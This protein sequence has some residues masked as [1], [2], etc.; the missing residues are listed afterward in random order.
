MLSPTLIT[1][2]LSDSPLCKRP[3]FKNESERDSMFGHKIYQTKRG[4]QGEAYLE[5]VGRTLTETEVEKL[6]FCKVR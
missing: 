2:R 5:N 3:L 6:P 4:K 1:S